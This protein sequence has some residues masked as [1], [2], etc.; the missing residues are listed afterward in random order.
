[1]TVM[2]QLSEMGIT[3]FSV[4]DVNLTYARPVTVIPDRETYEEVVTMED[5][6]GCKFYAETF[7]LPKLEK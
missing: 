2:E 6:N 5:A 4:Y 3:D 1:M 7:R